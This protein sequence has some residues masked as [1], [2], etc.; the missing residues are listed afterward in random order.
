[1]GQGVVLPTFYGKLAKSSMFGIK[2]YVL[3]RSYFEFDV[4]FMFEK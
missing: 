2:I 4:C 3:G 1:M